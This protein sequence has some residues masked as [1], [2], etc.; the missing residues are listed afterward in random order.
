MRWKRTP[1]GPQIPGLLCVYD[2]DGVCDFARVDL[3]DWEALK[4]RRFTI[5]GP[6]YVSHSAG[7]KRTYLHHML[8]GHVARG[9]GFQTDHLNRD[10][11]DNRRANVRVVPTGENLSNRGGHM[12]RCWWRQQAA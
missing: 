11:L 2:K 6:G 10:K 1:D 3:D 4:D 7:G 5:A 9:S 12:E 8:V